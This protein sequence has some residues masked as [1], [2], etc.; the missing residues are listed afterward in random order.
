MR[1]A[2]VGEVPLCHEGKS[3]CMIQNV[4]PALLAAFINHISIENL[5]LALKKFYPSPENTPGRMN[6]FNFDHFS[7][8]IDYAH[9][10]AGY[11]E[12][13]KYTAQLRAS[14][15]I[16]IIAAVADRPDQDIVNLGRLTAGIFD[17]IIIRHDAYNNG[18][19]LEEINGLLQRGI[20]E[21]RPGMPVHII[22]N[23]FEAIKYAIDHAVKDAWIFVNAENVYDTIFYVTNYKTPVL[24][25]LE[26]QPLQKR[27]IYKV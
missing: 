9:N 17:E 23:E 18:R 3:T 19:T 11:L 7:L 5:Q 4:L 26:L 6:V 27:V 20:A 1:I 10:E 14:M 21:V 12:L 15:K 16:G 13:K 2:R 8:M 25:R 24:K 22:S